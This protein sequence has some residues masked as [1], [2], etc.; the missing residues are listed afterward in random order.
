MSKIR[1]PKTLLCAVTAA[2]PFRLLDNLLLQ[3]SY[4]PKRL[5]NIKHKRFNVY[6]ACGMYSYYWRSR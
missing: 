1:R 4:S 3:L 2:F 6:V 5:L